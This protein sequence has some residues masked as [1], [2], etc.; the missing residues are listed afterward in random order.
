M[1]NV[2]PFALNPAPASHALYPLEVCVA[3]VSWMQAG[4]TVATGML[5]YFLYRRQT[6]LEDFCGQRNSAAG[7]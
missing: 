6:D 3:A 4:C 2:L 5:W 7:K 1:G